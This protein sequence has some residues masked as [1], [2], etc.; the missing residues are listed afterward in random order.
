METTSFLL[1]VIYDAQEIHMN[2]KCGE[3]PY[4]NP[5]DKITS[6]RILP[7]GNLNICRGMTIGNVFLHSIEK[8]LETYPPHSS[9]IFSVLYSKGVQGVYELAKEY[10]I[11][12]N[13]KDYYGICDFCSDCILFLKERG[14]K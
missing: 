6:V 4:T 9:Q 10:G 3:I 5:L 2:Q 12:I 8:I 7:N 13:P 14:V 1:V 11:I